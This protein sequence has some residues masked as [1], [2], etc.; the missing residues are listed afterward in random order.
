MNAADV[1]ALET[2]PIEDTTE[3]IK[4]K[5]ESAEPGAMLNRAT[6]YTGEA[7]ARAPTQHRSE[8]KKSAK[9]EKFRQTF[10]HVCSF[11]F[12][13]SLICFCVCCPKLTDV[14]EN[15]PEFHQFL[16]KYQ[17]LLD[18]QISLDFAPKILKFSE[19]DCRKVRRKLD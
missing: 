2:M 1:D 6:R 3:S 13:I 9:F 12:K 15:V 8:F 19:N 10:S 4:T 14:D 16:Q 5:H 7:Q 11:I 18:S 17:N